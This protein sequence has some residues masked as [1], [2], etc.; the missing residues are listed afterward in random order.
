MAKAG[1]LLDAAGYPLMGGQR[2]DRRGKPIVL[3]L[4]ATADNVPSQ[5]EG[6]L[7]TGW[8]QQ[9]GI[10]VQF[11]VLDAG[12]LSARVWN[13]DGAAYKPDF[14]LYI[15]S[16]LGY[17]DPGQTLLAET[18]AQIGATNE[19]CWSNVEYDRLAELQ[20]TQLDPAQRKQTLDRMQQIMYEQTP[21]VVV[22][23]P[24][25]FQAYNTAD[26][27]GWTRVNDGNGPAF[28]TAGN[29]D[30]YVNLKPVAAG[31]ASTGTSSSVWIALAAIA[32]AA[33]ALVAFLLR[34][35][36]RGRA[37]DE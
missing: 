14:D 8:L 10:K 6:K 4:Y 1:Q 29:V 23:Y 13:F 24:D 36:S 25:F 22:A 16:W 15:D 32:L 2:V 18:T 11:S 30:T 12:A 28:F 7:I 17:T 3:R 34:R 35:R 31:T 27:A 9:L 26:W 37:I 19:P 20:A 33:V 5:T 21:W